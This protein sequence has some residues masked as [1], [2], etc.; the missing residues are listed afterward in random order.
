MT[1]QLESTADFRRWLSRLDASVR[2]RL[3]ARL[4]RICLGNFGDH[5]QLEPDLYEMRFFFGS[6]YRV[7]YTLRDGRVVL[8]L[9]GGDKSSQARDIAK[10]KAIL[11]SLE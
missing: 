2:R 8:L 7:Y 9:A 5:R 10:A 3:L 1:Y 11:D 6:G 4:D